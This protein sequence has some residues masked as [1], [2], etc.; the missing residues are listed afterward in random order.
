MCHFYFE[1]YDTAFSRFAI[2]NRV[3]PAV[4]LVLVLVL[5]WRLLSL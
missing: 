5:A 4:L 1:R 3:L 2:G